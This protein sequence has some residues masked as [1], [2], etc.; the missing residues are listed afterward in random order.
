MTNMSTP[1]LV[2]GGST[3]IG[4]M[5][6]SGFAQ[7]GCKVYIASRKE[8][9]LKQYLSFKAVAEIRQRATAP[10]EYIVANLSSKAGC[11]ALIAEFKKR[12]SKLHI[13]VNNSGV[14]WGGIYE[15]IPE[16]KGWDN[17]F[18]VNVKSIFY[19]LLVKDSNSYDPARVI[20]IS[21]TA[22]VDPHT[23]HDLTAPG[24][25][26]W[27]YHP[28]KAAVNHLTSQ[29]AVKLGPRHVTF[30]P[31]GMTAFGLKLSGEE[32]YT[33]HQPTGRFGRTEDM[34]GL[35]LFLVSP[36]SAH[37]TGAHIILDGGARY[38]NFGY[39]I[40]GSGAAPAAKL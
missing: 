22:S 27:S 39:G 16:E 24:N 5:I 23:E 10:V 40:A 31:S 28:S 19:Y 11:D 15:D 1:A 9:S 3:G 37:V 25:G 26:T 13:L 33:S 7:N 34:A 30:F 12:E 17:I 21:S 18:A 29:L 36:A 20:N 14:A 2:T 6:A 8:D 35:A 4:K 38:G 32:R